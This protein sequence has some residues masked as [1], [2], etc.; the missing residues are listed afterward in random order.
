MNKLFE[1]IINKYF[2]YLLFKI[3]N[4]KIEEIKSYKYKKEIYEKIA[5]TKESAI[6]DIKVEIENILESSIAVINNEIEDYLD[7]E[8]DYTW[9]NE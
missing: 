2:S 1:K 9:S 4:P 6:I 7:I 3:W 8:N 5:E